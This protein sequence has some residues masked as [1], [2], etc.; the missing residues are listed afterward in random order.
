MI[1]NKIRPKQIRYYKLKACLK[2]Y[3]FTWHFEFDRV[4]RQ[5]IS[6][7]RLFQSS[8]AA[9]LNALPPSVGIILPL[10][11]SSVT[12]LLDLREHPVD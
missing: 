12:F 10:G 1:N 6:L 5:D 11:T 7:S 9:K 2:R 3:V 8:G 4:S